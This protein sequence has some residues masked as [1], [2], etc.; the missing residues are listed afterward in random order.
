MY[1]YGARF[2]MPD[3]GRWGVVDPL[4]EK[5]PSWSPYSYTFNNPIMF[6]DPTGMA[7]DWHKDGKGNLVADKG[8]NAQTLASYLH[9]TYSDALSILGNNGYA[10]NEKGVLNL[11]VGSTVTLPDGYMNVYGGGN[12]DEVVLKPGDDKKENTDAPW[13]KIAESQI[14]VREKTGKNDGAQVEK[15]L[16]TGGLGKGHAWCGAF[17]N[18]T[19][20]E[21]NI[22]VTGVKGNPN[23]ALN[24]RGFGQKLDSPAFGAVATKTRNGGGHVGFVAGKTST[25]RLIILGGNQSDMVN[26]TSYPSS[27]FKFNY[28][29]GYKPNYTLPTLNISSGKIKEN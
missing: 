2:Y 17:V 21:S 10:Q 15:Y 3:I 8:D 5:M 6:I 19:F 28:P 26:Y 20:E 18:W 25:G 12:I 1:D 11:Q 27:I 24:W 7:P 14:G 22:S 4:A 23:W 9:T 29:S 16:K 13:M